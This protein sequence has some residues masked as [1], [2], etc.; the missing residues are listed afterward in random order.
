MLNVVCWSHRY[1]YLSSYQSP[2]V[3]FLGS[4]QFIHMLRWS[5]NHII[6]VLQY[7]TGVSRTDPAEFIPLFLPLLQIWILGLYYDVMRLSGILAC[8]LS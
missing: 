4:G 8:N 3:V 5:T 1:H 6:M 2:L 7:C